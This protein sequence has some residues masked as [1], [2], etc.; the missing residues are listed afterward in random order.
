MQNWRPGLVQK[1]SRSEPGIPLL[2]DIPKDL[3]WESKHLG[4]LASDLYRFIGTS[5]V[6]SF[7]SSV[8]SVKPVL[9]CVRHRMRCLGSFGAGPERNI[10]HCKV[11]LE[12]RRKTTE[13]DRL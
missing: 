8:K 9:S 13:F 12:V 6:D 1:V 4:I 10:D 11:D 5:G 2:E 7:A 3:H